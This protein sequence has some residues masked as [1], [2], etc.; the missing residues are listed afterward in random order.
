M[1]LQ[2]LEHILVLA[3]D[4]DETRDFY[5]DVLGMEVGP[6][7][8]FDFDGHWLYIG[9]TPAVHLAKSGSD[10]A[11]TSYFK[12][13]GTSEGEGGGAVDHAAFSGTG[14]AE[15]VARLER[16]AIT[17]TRATVPLTGL[18]QVFL[19]DPNGVKLEINFDAKE[20][21]T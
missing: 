12:D 21:A 1:T 8:P 17:H 7:P 10:R 5:V 15:F 11:L 14:L 13:A 9:D 4:L 16:L 6:R 3:K 2:R 20:A 18:Q 19:H